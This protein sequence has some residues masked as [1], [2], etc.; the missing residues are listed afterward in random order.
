MILDLLGS[1]ERVSGQ[2]INRS[3]TTQFFSKSTLDD[4]KEI[5]RCLLGVQEIQHYEKYLGHPSFV[6]E[7]KKL[8]LTTLRRRC[9]RNCKGGKE[10]YYHKQDGRC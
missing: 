10:N 4:T 2:K 5:I 7:E 9:G 1:Y 8:V 3:K 6:G